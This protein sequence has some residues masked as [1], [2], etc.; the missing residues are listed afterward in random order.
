M[1][2]APVLKDK[3]FSKRNFGGGSLMLWAGFSYYGKTTLAFTSFKMNS[4]AY[5]TVLQGHLIP[6]IM[7]VH[8]GEAIFQQD[9]AAIHVSRETKE[10]LTNSGINFI[11]WPAISPDCNPMEN[12]WG[13]L[14]QR[15]YA[16]NRQYETVQDLKSA[17]IEAWNGNEHNI[18][19]NLIKSMRNRMIELLKKNGN[20]IDY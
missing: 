9:N 8:E 10:W 11:N 3:Y 4:R 1:C 16:D 7:N 14:V 17:V 18:L 2:R 20:K 12:L 19:K 15:I 5:I 6:F 13:V